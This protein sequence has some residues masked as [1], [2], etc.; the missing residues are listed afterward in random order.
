M[1]KR[2]KRRMKKPRKIHVYRGYHLEPSE[3]IFPEPAKKTWTVYLRSMTMGSFKTLSA[4]RTAIDEW[5]AL[6]TD[7]RVR[8][9]KI[10][11]ASRV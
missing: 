4:A 3:L 5:L 1:C 9:E 8:A 7:G 6:P 2:L 11:T 10:E